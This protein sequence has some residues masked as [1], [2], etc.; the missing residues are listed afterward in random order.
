MSLSLPNFYI[1]VLLLYALRCTHSALNDV[2]I[3]SDLQTTTFEHAEY[4]QANQ[5]ILRYV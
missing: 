2:K 3:D 4:W 1:S 5:S